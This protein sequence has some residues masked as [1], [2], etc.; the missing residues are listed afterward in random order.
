MVKRD[1]YKYEFKVVNKIKHKGVTNDLQRRESEHQQK[2][3]KGHI[4]QVGR[5]VTEY[6]ARKW[7]KKEGVS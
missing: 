6:S 1:T 2:W 5:A 3:P 7:E 4:K